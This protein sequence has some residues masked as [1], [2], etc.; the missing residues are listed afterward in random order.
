MGCFGNSPSLGENVESLITFWR[1][2]AAF[3]ARKKKSYSW[4]SPDVL[5]IVNAQLH[6]LRAGSPEAISSFPAA[7]H[8]KTFCKLWIF[9]PSSHPATDGKAVRMARAGGWHGC[10]YFNKAWRLKFH[11]CPSAVCYVHSFII[12][13]HFSLQLHFRIVVFWI[14]VTIQHSSHDPAPKQGIQDP[15]QDPA[16]HQPVGHFQPTEIVLWSCT[17]S[18]A[19]VRH[20]KCRKES[21]K[22]GEYV[23]TGKTIDKRGKKWRRQL[24]GLK[25]VQQKRKTTAQDRDL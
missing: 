5:P 19:I 4:S 17:T 9:C 18:S 3:K 25:M 8:M 23:G 20:Q 10:V 16:Q 6:L 11:Q 13:S 12:I 2:S 14:S 7:L 15:S 1:S 22:A 21:E 24:R